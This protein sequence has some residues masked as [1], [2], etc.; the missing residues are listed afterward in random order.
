MAPGQGFRNVF[1]FWSHYQ[2]WGWGATKKRRDPI[3]IAGPPNPISRSK[4]SDLRPLEQRH[5]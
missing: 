3:L 1:D 4:N 2:I 5:F